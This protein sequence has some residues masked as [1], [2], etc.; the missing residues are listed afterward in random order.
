MAPGDRSMKGWKTRFRKWAGHKGNPRG[1]ISRDKKILIATN[2]LVSLPL[3]SQAGE[4]IPLAMCHITLCLLTPWTDWDVVTYR[5]QL[6][7]LGVG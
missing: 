6:A 7:R 4:S 2:I 5:C 1:Q 3:D